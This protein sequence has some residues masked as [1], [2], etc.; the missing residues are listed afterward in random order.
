MCTGLQAG[1][2]KELA[3]VIKK[4]V[5]SAGAAS[6]YVQ[7]SAS[8]LGAGGSS[9]P[10]QGHFWHRKL[11]SPPRYLTEASPCWLQLGYVDLPTH[12]LRS[13]SGNS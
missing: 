12:D 4:S 10:R 3:N 2:I 1:E 7:Y 6:L 8:R 5:V 11:Q 13:S 9:E